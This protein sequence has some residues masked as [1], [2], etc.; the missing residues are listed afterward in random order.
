MSPSRSPHQQAGSNA[1]CDCSRLQPASGGPQMRHAGT[2]TSCVCGVSHDN[3]LRG[4]VPWD[5][6][7]IIPGCVKHR[8]NH[9]TLA[10][11]PCAGEDDGFWQTQAWRPTRPSQL[12]TGRICCNS[13]PLVFLMEAAAR[14]G[15]SLSS[16]SKRRSHA[17]SQH[18]MH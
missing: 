6:V 17:F 9:L 3:L 1:V 10:H 16:N 12:L 7:S 11:T 14:A 8:L 13:M 5:L 15:L 18:S 2:L 4:L